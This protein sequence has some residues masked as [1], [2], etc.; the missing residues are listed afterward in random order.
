MRGERLKQLREKV[1]IS[2]KDLA[3]RLGI[4]ESQIYKYEKEESEPRAD[5]VVK[6]AEFFNVSTDFLMGVSDEFGSFYK[7][8]LT[9]TERRV[10]AAMRR[11][12]PIEAIHLIT[13]EAKQR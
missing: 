12:D 4:S 11:G 13:G 7:D 1:K 6:L 5:T 10:L 8:E 2:Q 3:D 9:P